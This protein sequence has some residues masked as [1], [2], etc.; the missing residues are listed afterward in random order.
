MVAVWTVQVVVHQ[1][2][3]MI[4]MG[5]GFM[6]AVRTMDMPGMIGL[7]SVV[8]RALRWMLAIDLDH[9]LIDVIPVHVMQVAIVQVIGMPIMIDGDMA[10][11][12]PMPVVMTCMCLTLAH[13]RYPR[14]LMAVCACAIPVVYGKDQQH[15]NQA[16]HP[17]SLDEN[18][19]VLLNA[20]S[21]YISTR[22][23]CCT[24]PRSGSTP[25]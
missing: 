12:G 13:D 20:T 24:V 6:P 5:H 22:S 15:L 17:V 9:M 10:A 25:P 14:C 16:P 8:G 19:R 2:I 4:P 3:D 21:F 1:I 23:S 18:G 11:V 7:T